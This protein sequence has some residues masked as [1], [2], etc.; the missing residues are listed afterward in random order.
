MAGAGFLL[1]DFDAGAVGEFDDG[2]RVVAMI[3][4]LVDVHLMQRQ[5]EKSGHLLGHP[6]A[7]DQSGDPGFSIDRVGDTDHP[8]GEGIAV[9][10]DID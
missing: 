3:D 4:E 2:I 5:G 6:D 10:G 8:G 9:F 1:R 7:F